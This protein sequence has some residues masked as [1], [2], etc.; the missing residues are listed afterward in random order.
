MHRFFMKLSILMAYLG[1][2]M[3]ATLILLTCASIIGRE[4]NDLMHTLISA[5]V[6]PGVAQWVLDLGIGPVNGDYEL[7]E[8]GMAFSIFAFLP[9]C[10]M[11]SGHATVDIFTNRM[12]VQTN[13]VLRLLT[14]VVFAMILVLIAV[15]LF[16]GMQ[17]KIR[18]GQTTFLLEYPVWWGYALSLVGAVVVAMVSIY[19]AIIRALEVAT[20]RTLLPDGAGAEH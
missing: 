9:L 2:A 14:D 19:V 1:G 17:S 20:G 11:T 12:S 15:Q 16:S 5:E 18:S 13:R 3:L 4:L 8:A 10:Q 6:F 7:V